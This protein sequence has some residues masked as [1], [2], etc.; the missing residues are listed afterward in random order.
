MRNV[1]AALLALATLLGA[2][3]VAAQCDPC[4]RPCMMDEARD[5]RLMGDR[6]HGG[7]QPEWST[8]AEAA[9]S[10]RDLERRIDRNCQ[11]ARE[12]SRVIPFPA[13][14][15]IADEDRQMEELADK[16]LRALIDRLDRRIQELGE[17]L[18]CGGVCWYPGGVLPRAPEEY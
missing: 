18:N 15:S 4:D 7:P 6:L 16:Q 1:V 3:P 5:D 14:L 12:L 11:E 17:R 13:L 9:A 8:P 10:Q 2:H